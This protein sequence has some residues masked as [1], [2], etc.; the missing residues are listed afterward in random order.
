MDGLVSARESLRVNDNST[1]NSI[2]NHILFSNPLLP[3]VFLVYFDLI[4][5]PLLSASWK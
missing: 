1:K 2:K 5:D 3:E 4:L